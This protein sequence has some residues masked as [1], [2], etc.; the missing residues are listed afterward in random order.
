[1]LDLDAGVHFDE[2]PLLGIHVVEELDGAGVVVADVASE[3]GGGFAEFMTEVALEID[4]GGD[5]DDLLV[6]T[7]DRAITL[8]QVDDVPVLVAEDL[9]FDVLGALDV[10]LEEDGVVSEG[11][12]GFFL[13]LGE[14]SLE[15]GG[16]FDDAHAATATTEGSLDDE[17]EADFVRDGEGLV[18]I[19]NGV[20]S[21]GEDGDIG[22][23]G[24]SASGGFVAHGAEEVGGWSDEGDAFTSAGAGEVG[25]FREESVAGVD[26]SDAFGFSESDDAFVVEVSTDG[27]F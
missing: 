25:I 3:T 26:E 1:V 4:G 10:A 13:R 7:L 24:L 21:S 6:A 17:R 23:D 8:V 9:H 2:E 20:V 11:V 15:V 27:A 14:E 12:L 18:G 5:F 16:L 19:G 22:G